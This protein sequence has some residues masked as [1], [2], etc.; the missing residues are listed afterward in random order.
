MSGSDSLSVNMH[1]DQYHIEGPGTQS[2]QSR[3][4]A[5]GAL[6]AISQGVCS[7]EVGMGA[8]LGPKP[9]ASTR[10]RDVSLG[11]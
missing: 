7:Q 5:H 9:T 3:D 6:T 10:D 1:P 11:A 4:S 8:E 2:R